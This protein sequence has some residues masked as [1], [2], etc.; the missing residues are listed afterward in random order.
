MDHDLWALP[1]L[2]QVIEETLRLY[3][4]APSV[5]ARVVPPQG[6]DIGGYHIKG[7]LN[8]LRPGVQ[9]PSEP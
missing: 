8:R 4:A 5:P 1:Y 9:P 3:A 2:N 6:A 7:G